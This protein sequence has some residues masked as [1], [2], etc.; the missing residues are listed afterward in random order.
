MVF[1]FLCYSL[2]KGVLVV[3]LSDDESSMF[4]YLYYLCLIN[5]YIL[6]HFL[7]YFFYKL[8]NAVKLNIFELA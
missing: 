7:K 5:G 1:N 4:S 2:S 6:L 8:I 3:R